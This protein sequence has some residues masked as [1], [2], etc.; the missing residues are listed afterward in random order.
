[1][2][3][4]RRR[5]TPCPPCPAPSLSTL[6]YLST[7][8]L[9]LLSPPSATASPSPSTPSIESLP[10]TTLHVPLYRQNGHL[11]ALHKR[12]TRPER[13]ELVRE[14]AIREKGRVVNKYGQSEERLRKRQQSNPD[15]I[16]SRIMFSTA[17]VGASGSVATSTVSGTVSGVETTT[18][19]TRTSP[20]TSATP[21]GP[22]GLVRM[23]NYEADL[24][25]FAPVAIGVPPQYM[26]CILDTGSADLWIASTNCSSLTGCSTTTPLYN[27]TQSATR[28]DM[29]TTFSVKYGGGSAQGEIWQDYVGFAGYNVSSQAFALIEDINGDLLGQGISGLMGLGWQPLAASRVTPFWQN[30]FSASVLPFPGFAVSLTR[31]NNVSTASSVEP[32]GSLTIGYLNASLY[33]SEINYVGIP[34]GMESYWVVPMEQVTVNGTN[35]TTEG[36]ASQYVAIDT[37]TTLIGGPRDVV[38]NLYAQVEGAQA[39]TGRYTGYY[40]YPCEHNVSVSLTFG[41]VAYNMSSSDFNLGPFGIDSNTNRST[42]LGAFFDLSF[43]SS[44][45]VSWVIGASFLKNVYSVYRASPPSV[46]FATLSNSTHHP[47]SS[48]SSSNGSNN[49]NSSAPD[50]NITAIPGLYGPSGTVS[51]RTTLVPANTITTAVMAG[52]TFG[53]TPSSA[54]K[55]FEGKWLGAVIGGVVLAMGLL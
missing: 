41:G 17:G 31:Y 34:Q 30:L 37:G 38:G 20:Q 36:G 24:S 47:T 50:E 15:V 53:R 7:A 43:G 8:L 44:S 19:E 45:R 1:M 35:V 9:V 28:L 48:S 12:S 23:Q 21:T 2:A 25:Y 32:G 54:S 14:W 40:S 55:G 52:E 5:V 49:S 42:C 26:S 22:V 29:N 18:T 27:T 11:H 39:A 3:R 13:E 46:G 4:D 6:L 33:S 10:E 51:V 16:S